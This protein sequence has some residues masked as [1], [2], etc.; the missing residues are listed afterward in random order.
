MIKKF[1]TPIYITRPLLPNLDQIQSK[2]KEIWESKWLTNM[3]TQHK[4]LEERLK[5][6]LKVKN[7]VLYNNGTLALLLGIRALNLSDEVI[8]TPFTFPA[9]VE[10]LDWNGIT[11]VFCDIDPKTL[12][13]DP[14]KIES[15]I[16][17]K[18]TAILGVHVF[19]T[20]CDVEAIQTIAN[21][22]KLKV[23]YDS[24]HAFGTEI[25]G[26]PIGNF[27][28]LTMFS[29]HA[30]KLFHTIEGGALT[31]KNSLLRQKLDLLK[32]F[33]I[34]GPEEVVLSG[35]NAKMNEVQAAIGLE[36]LLM[37]DEERKKRRKIKQIYEESLKE[38]RGINIIN[39]FNAEKNSFQYF[40][41][42]IDENIFGKSRDWVHEELKKYNI[43]TRK[44]FYPLCSSFKWYNT[45][46]SAK[47]DNLPVANSL[48]KQVLSLPFYGELTFETIEKISGIIDNLK[49]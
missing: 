12:N 5:R 36:V 25:K 29:F 22:H 11:P 9:T 23:I 18:T 38:I 28:D 21:K 35:L 33:G 20:P 43:F 49:L 31:F 42:T 7:L 15:L 14:S 37:V 46:S 3:G 40:V 26:N 6:Y 1:K 17:E 4:Q 19:G 41:I 27:G 39:N 13:I 32:N 34:S 10:A 44:Y 8:T 2:L 24:A 47:P 16:T 30:T 45:L 48:V